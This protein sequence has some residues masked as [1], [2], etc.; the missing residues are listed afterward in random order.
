VLTVFC[1]K[2]GAEL[3]PGARFCS[4]CGQ[5]VGLAEPT[6][7]TAGVQTYTVTFTREKQWFA[8]NPA[9]KIIVDERDEYRIDNGET[10]RVPMTGGVHGVTFRCGVRNKVIQLEVAGDLS[11][12]LRWNRLTGSLI[13]K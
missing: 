5:E 7:E 8:I 13:V 10:I 9:V 6:A 4:K 12:N 1:P 2:C 11:L 3:V